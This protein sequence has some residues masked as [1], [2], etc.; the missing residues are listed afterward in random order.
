[1]Y[2][3]AGGKSNALQVDGASYFNG[4]MGINTSSPVSILDVRGTV[5]V[6]GTINMSGAINVTGYCN[7]CW[8][9]SKCLWTY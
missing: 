7:Y 6:T 3:T 8:R 2:I 4:N 5:S 1:M 9:Q